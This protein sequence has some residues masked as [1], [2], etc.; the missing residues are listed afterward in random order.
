MW[1]GR[2]C[3]DEMRYVYKV[4]DQCLVHSK[5]GFVNAGLL[6]LSYMKMVVLCHLNA[7]D[8]IIVCIYMNNNRKCSK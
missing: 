3:E 7:Q 6:V 8:I 2:D 5:H 1:E 4:L